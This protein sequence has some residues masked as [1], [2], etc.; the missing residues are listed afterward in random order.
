METLLSSSAKWQGQLILFLA[1]WL[2]YLILNMYIYNQILNIRKYASLFFKFL[3]SWWSFLG[4]TMCNNTNHACCP[5][6]LLKKKKKPK[7]N[8]NNKKTSSRQCFN[9]IL[10]QRR[11]IQNAYVA[12]VT[13]QGLRLACFVELKLMEIIQAC[14][15]K[16]GLW[17]WL[18][19]W[20][21]PLIEL[22]GSMLLVYEEEHKSL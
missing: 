8:N 12:S 15:N 14:W 6:E 3:Y 13:E 5:V 2:L 19:L 4:Y 18:T 20:R 16:L 7:L 10:I 11:F 9:I 21:N 22:N 1:L 17:S